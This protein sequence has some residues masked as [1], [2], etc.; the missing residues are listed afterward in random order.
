[1][2]LPE[3][4]QLPASGCIQAVLHTGVQPVLCFCNTSK[5]WGGGEKW[6]LEAALAMARRGYRVFLVCQ[7]NSALYERAGE[8]PELELFPVRLGRFSFL[9]PMF[10][11]VLTNFLRHNAVHAVVLNLPSDLK[12]I[13]PAAQKAGVA[14]IFYRRGSAIAVKNSWMN[15]RLFGLLTGVIVNSQAT[16]DTLLQNNTSLVAPERVHLLPN[17]VDIAAFDAA[18]QALP[19]QPDKGTPPAQSTRPL[20]IGTAGRLSPEKAQHLL[21]LL[22]AAL[23]PLGVPFQLVIAGSGPRL[24]AL[25]A[26]AERLGVQE[27]VEFMGFQENLASF[28]QRIDLFVLPSLWEGFGYV[29]VEAMLARK[30]VFAFNVSNM[31]N[32]VQQGVNGR[33]FPLPRGAETLEEAGPLQQMAEAAMQLWQHPEQGKA[34]GEAGRAFVEA[35]FSQEAAMHTL[36]ALLR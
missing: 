6:H 12:C 29:L 1:M 22:G 4:E 20:V 36:E 3:R 13:A 14:R 9:N 11:G 35:N 15:R 31:P 32:L 19:E 27:H 26:L 21:L 5:T 16:R 17:G 7:A 30:P 34:M 2:N 25:H 24:E 28:W 10:M 18:L 23:Q 8:H 33:L